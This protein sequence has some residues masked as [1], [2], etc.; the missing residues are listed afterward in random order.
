[1]SANLSE[2]Q[3]LEQMLMVS[4]LE[5]HWEW[6]SLSS[7]SRPNHGDDKALPNGYSVF[8][9]Q[10]SSCKKRSWKTWHHCIHYYIRLN[11]VFK[12]MYDLS[13]WCHKTSVKK[14][15]AYWQTNIRLKWSKRA[16]VERLVHTSIY[17]LTNTTILPK[18]MKASLCR[19]QGHAEVEHS[20]STNKKLSPVNVLCCAM[21]QTTKDAVRITGHGQVHA[22]PIIQSFMQACKSAYSAYKTRS[23]RQ[24]KVKK[25]K[26]QRQKDQGK[27]E[28]KEQKES[29]MSMKR[30]KRRLEDRE[31][32]CQ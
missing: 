28:A 25:A 6:W 9:H 13:R 22:M 10:A 29:I 21:T 5:N 2:N 7:K 26:E 14:K 18:L 20:L 30:K 12:L 32:I 31:K 4:P 19:F 17:E 3:M 15:S 1:M 11:M 27:E 24:E 16:G 23:T 8:V